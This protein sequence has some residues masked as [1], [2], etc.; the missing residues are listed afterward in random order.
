MRVF[1]IATFVILAIGGWQCLAQHSNQES[2]ATSWSEFVWAPLELGNTHIEKG[3]MLVPVKVTGESATYYMQLDL[4]SDVSM[5]YQIPYAELHSRGQESIA[6]RTS[7]T[8]QIANTRLDQVAFT[9]RQGG[10]SLNKQGSIA[11]IGTI[12]LDFLRN[13]VL[14]IDYPRQR[15]AMLDSDTD[16]R[17]YVNHTVTFVGAVHRNDKF[18]VPLRIAGKTYENDFFFDTGASMFPLSTTPD[19]WRSLTGRG[20][21]EASNVVLEVPSWGS[22]I[23]LIGAP[24]KGTLEIG[25]AR[26]EGPLAFFQSDNADDF[27]KWPFPIKGLF[28]NALFFDRMIVVD[29]PHQRFGVTR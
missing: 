17:A 1:G 14:V 21:E 12:G 11:I 28:G 18:F 9:L 7:F 13:R 19:L 3:A 23:K 25:S 2:T 27:S 29:V 8:G 26:I 20:G 16:V 10:T 6:S 22:Q 24:L 15:L 4:G 5:F